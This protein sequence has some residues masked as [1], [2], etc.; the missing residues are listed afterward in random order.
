MLPAVPIM[1]R[2]EESA[3]SDPEDKLDNIYDPL[4]SFIVCINIVWF[5]YERVFLWWGRP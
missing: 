2:D 3:L 1:Y 4:P 5:I